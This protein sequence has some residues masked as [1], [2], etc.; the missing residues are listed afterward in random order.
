M[1][2]QISILWG[3]VWPW[4]Q[5]AAVIATLAL[6]YQGGFLT[7]VGIAL[8]YILWIIVSGKG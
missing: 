5:P 6:V 8:L 3:R 4:I 2:E 1:K 7:V